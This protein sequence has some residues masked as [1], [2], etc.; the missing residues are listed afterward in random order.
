MIFEKSSSNVKKLI[1]L[2]KKKLSLSTVRGQ[3]KLKPTTSITIH[4]EIAK[5]FVTSIFRGDE[6]NEICWKKQRLWVAILK[7]PIEETV[8]IKK[9]TPLGFLVVEAKHLKFQ[10]EM[11]KK[12][13]KVDQKNLSVYKLKTKEA[14]W[15][16]S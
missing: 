1:H 9:S 6:I 7:N 15:R 2:K 13:K 16:F 11:T 5:G 4:T 14:T 3:L 12:K 10:Y 8:E